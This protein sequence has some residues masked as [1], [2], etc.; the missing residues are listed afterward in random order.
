MPMRM[1]C[2]TGISAVLYVLTIG[3]GRPSREN[4]RFRPEEAN[5]GW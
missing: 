2:N 5:P 3:S 1:V 4:A